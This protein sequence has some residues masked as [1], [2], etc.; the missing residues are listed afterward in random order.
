[1]EACAARQEA[2]E[3]TEGWFETDILIS[4]G[5]R[6]R[7][8]DGLLTNFHL[9]EST[10]L[11]MVASLLE[12][13]VPRLLEVYRLAVRERMRFFS[14]AMRCSCCRERWRI[15]AH[16]VREAGGV[17]PIERRKTG[18]DAGAGAGRAGLGAGARAAMRLGQLIHGL[19]VR[20]HDCGC[21]DPLL[22]RVC[23]I[24]EDSRTV[25][26]GSLFIA[27][28]GLK[29]DGKTFVADAAEAGASPW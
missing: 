15:A 12:G 17:E 28:S 14:T 29:A 23:D 1:M 7:W 4:P 5:H 10:L 9:P 11:A 3:P 22:V 13:G 16:K 21:A 6:W 18:T 27:R 26:P 2:G 20:L 8:A 19:D 24:T 25:V